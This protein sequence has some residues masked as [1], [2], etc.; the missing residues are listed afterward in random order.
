MWLILT[1]LFMRKKGGLYEKSKKGVM[2][3]IMRHQL[4]PSLVSGGSA[5]TGIVIR[6]TS[7]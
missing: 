1:Y 4:P 2:I 6:A 3:C 7:R 5:G